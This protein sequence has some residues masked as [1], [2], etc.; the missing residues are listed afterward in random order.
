MHDAIR[1]AMEFLLI[2]GETNF[3]EVLKIHEIRKIYSPRKKSAL[4]YHMNYIQYRDVI[5]I[6]LT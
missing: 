4:R 5:S 1:V 2:F 6:Q 3:V